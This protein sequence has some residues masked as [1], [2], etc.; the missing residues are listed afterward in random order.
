MLKNGLCAEVDSH[1]SQVSEPFVAPG[2]EHG[3]QGNPAVYS[4]KHRTGG[5][6]WS[7]D[8]AGYFRPFLQ[9]VSSTS[10]K[11]QVTEINPRK[12]SSALKKLRQLSLHEF[13]KTFHD[14]PTAPQNKSLASFSKTTKRKRGKFSVEKNSFRRNMTFGSDQKSKEHQSRAASQ[15]WHLKKKSEAHGGVLIKFR[16][17]NYRHENNSF[18]N[19]IGREENETVSLLRRAV[20]SSRK[21]RNAETW[22]LK[23]FNTKDEVE[24]HW[25]ATIGGNLDNNRF[26]FQYPGLQKDFV[27]H[28]L[29]LRFTESTNH[30]AGALGNVWNPRNEIRK[31]ASKVQFF[32]HRNIKPDSKNKREIKTN[33]PDQFVKEIPRLQR[34]HSLS[35]KIRSLSDQRNLLYSERENITKEN[36]K[37]YSVRH[38]LIPTRKDA[39]KRL[40]EARFDRNLNGGK[41]WKEDVRSNFIQTQPSS[42]ENTIPMIDFLEIPVYYEQEYLNSDHSHIFL[43]E[44]KA[45]NENEGV[46]LTPKFKTS[47]FASQINVV[48]RMATEKYERSY[49]I[50]EE[51]NNLPEMR[52]FG[53]SSGSS[54]AKDILA[55]EYIANLNI[56]HNQGSWTDHELWNTN[57]QSS[58]DFVNNSENRGTLINYTIF[59]RNEAEE[60]NRSNDSISSFMQFFLGVSAESADEQFSNLDEITA[61]LTRPTLPYRHEGNNYVHETL[62]TV[63]DGSLNSP[64]PRKQVPQ[65]NEMDGI[66]VFKNVN[67]INR[68]SS[69]EG[70]KTEWSSGPTFSSHVLQHSDHENSHIKQNEAQ[71]PQIV[72]NP[73]LHHFSVPYASRWHSSGAETTNGTLD[74]TN[75]QQVSNR[76]NII[77]PHDGTQSIFETNNTSHDEKTSS[78]VGASTA[79]ISAFALDVTGNSARNSKEHSSASEAVKF[80]S[81]EDNV[82]QLPLA[83]DFLITIPYKSSEKFRRSSL[84]HASSVYMEDPRTYSE[85]N[86]PPSSKILSSLQSPHGIDIGTH[87]LVSSVENFPSISGFLTNDGRSYV[88]NNRSLCGPECEGSIGSLQEKFTKTNDAAGLFGNYSASLFG[89]DKG[90]KNR[91]MAQ[92]PLT[93]FNSFLMPQW[94]ITPT[95]KV[96]P[97]FSAKTIKTVEPSLH[98]HSKLK[99]EVVPADI[100]ES[101]QRANDGSKRHEFM[102][103]K[104]SNRTNND[105]STF[106]SKART[107]E[108]DKLI[109]RSVLHDGRRDLED[110]QSKPELKINGD[111]RDVADIFTKVAR[112]AVAEV[113]A[114]AKASDL[115]ES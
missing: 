18:I 4:V 44:K 2:P 65:S 106:S 63:V 21:K 73:T 37:N 58:E 28:N 74:L 32:N 16:S 115:N 11:E 20:R 107:L 25:E 6:R 35:W 19:R 91:Q 17:K 99:D 39:I 45:K 50:L 67:L 13:E 7:T 5:R 79:I 40:R 86:S 14:S 82:L 113:A 26:N 1:N 31:T 8:K 78:N 89:L 96:S 90:N 87:K 112:T 114:M 70:L 49:T 84:Q 60:N 66:N 34:R 110:R 53:H 27:F 85:K 98:P 76:V 72:F 10:E 30:P 71:P 94:N 97:N 109:D 38:L 12:R 88:D 15:G 55:D 22:E 54:N 24:K 101:I 102:I 68:K 104:I 108:L 83:T 41:I 57:G 75:Q 29:G 105:Q 46:I 80:L 77:D 62:S 61:A 95:T 103:A 81:L 92:D 23:H 56:S 42:L 69:A 100:R 48:P 9:Q 111:F 47:Q 59:N 43:N 52:N 64:W 93:N 36:V 3:D 51:P 33:K